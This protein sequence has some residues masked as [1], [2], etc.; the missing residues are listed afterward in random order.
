MLAEKHE[1]Q[2][3]QKGNKAFTH[4][5]F[6]ATFRRHWRKR[7]DKQRNA[8]ERIGDEDK[9]DEWLEKIMVHGQLCQAIKVVQQR[10]GN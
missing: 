4:H 8:S 9:Q 2:Q 3:N 7:A 10:L 6:P 5:D 1:Q